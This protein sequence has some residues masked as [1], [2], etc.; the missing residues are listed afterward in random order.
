[1]IDPGRYNNEDNAF[2]I[3]EN[4]SDSYS[5]S[6]D[7]FISDS[8][9]IDSD[10]EQILKRKKIKTRIINVPLKNRKTC[11]EIFT[12]CDK[13]ITFSYE[14]W[15]NTVFD[16]PSKKFRTSTYMDIIRAKFRDCFSCIIQTRDTYTTVDQLTIYTRKCAQPKC[17]RYYKLVHYSQYEKMWDN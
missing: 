7:T 15:S 4:D 2:T 12:Q 10:F 13:E 8:S 6:M 9:S 1:M 3:P 14:E 11:R 16:A 5:S 17:E